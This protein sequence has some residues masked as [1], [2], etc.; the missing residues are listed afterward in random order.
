MIII[1]MVVMMMTLMMMDT[2]FSLPT[3]CQ[4]TASSVK[5]LFHYTPSPPMKEASVRDPVIKQNV[6]YFSWAFS[7]PCLCVVCLCAWHCEWKC[8]DLYIS[9]VNRCKNIKRIMESFS[10]GFSGTELWIHN[11]FF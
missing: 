7:H 9:W 2:P 8:E 10:P 3:D 1:M 6:N 11:S 4:K 5:A